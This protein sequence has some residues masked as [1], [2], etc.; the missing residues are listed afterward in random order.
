MLEFKPER[1]EKMVD[2]F[3]ST[4][5]GL[6]LDMFMIST[7]DYDIYTLETHIYALSTKLACPD[8]AQLKVNAA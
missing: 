6:N 8:R 2:K 5:H 1:G 7:E 4:V 3:F